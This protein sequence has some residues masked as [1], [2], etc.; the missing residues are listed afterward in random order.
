MVMW[1]VKMVSAISS[2]YTTTTATTT[3][4]LPGVIHAVDYFPHEG[5]V[6]EGE[7]TQE[8]ST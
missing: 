8:D 7:D 5:Q 2:E 1:Y 4:I 3:I 6:E